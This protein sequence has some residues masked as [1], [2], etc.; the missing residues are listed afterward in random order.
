MEPGAAAFRVLWLNS[1]RL[2]FFGAWKPH[3]STAIL[4]TA[5]RKALAPRL[6]PDHAIERRRGPHQIP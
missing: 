5:T 3:F 2:A 4:L 6:A 1:I